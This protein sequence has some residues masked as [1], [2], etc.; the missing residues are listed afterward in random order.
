MR[1]TNRNKHAIYLPLPFSSL[2]SVMY[3][4]GLLAIMWLTLPDSPPRRTNRWANKLV[5]QDPKEIELPSQKEII[6][7]N[8]RICKARRKPRTLPQ[9]C[10]Q[11]MLLSKKTPSAR[12]YNNSRQIFQVLV[13]KFPGI[14]D[15]YGIY[16]DARVDIQR[17]VERKTSSLLVGEN[18]HSIHFLSLHHIYILGEGR[19]FRLLVWFSHKQAW[20]QLTGSHSWTP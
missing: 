16:I 2:Q 7:D 14:L 1:K 6:Y 4:M 20:N 12:Y 3:V 9:E 15:P 13:L 5:S 8:P 11:T 10:V 17:Y 19:P 18:I